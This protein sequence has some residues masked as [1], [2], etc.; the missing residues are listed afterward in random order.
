MLY[1]LLA[2]VL[3]SAAVS[4]HIALCR[5]ASK[6][7]LHTREFFIL[8]ACLLGVYA[9]AVLLWPAPDP[10]TV[11]GL[12]LKITSAAIFILLVP[13]YLIFYVLTQLT[14]PSKKMVAFLH[15]K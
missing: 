4:S 1:L 9:L 5:R 3:F 6:T 13:V 7:H 8:S 10:K 14:S 2:L 12:P 11:W 15:A